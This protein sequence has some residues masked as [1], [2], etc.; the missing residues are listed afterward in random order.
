MSDVCRKRDLLTLSDWDERV[1]HCPLD[2]VATGIAKKKG[3]GMQRRSTGADGGPCL[4]HPCRAGAVTTQAFR[5]RNGSDKS[6]VF[7]EPTST[8]H[9]KITSSK[10][11]QNLPVH[12][13]LIFFLLKFW[14]WVWFPPDLKWLI[15]Q[16]NG[17]LLVNGSRA[18]LPT[19][20][21]W[22]NTWS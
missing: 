6:C 11:A 14:P 3:T 1:I 10:V 5:A 8:A 21:A 17:A 15:K 18:Q 4:V 7:E 16:C 22:S 9:C 20:H 12:G 13:D 2:D 19:T